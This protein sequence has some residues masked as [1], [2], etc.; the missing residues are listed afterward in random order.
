M[1]GLELPRATVAPPRKADR[2]WSFAG[3][4]VASCVAAAAWGLDHLWPPASGAIL[5]IVLGGGIRTSLPL[6]AAWIEACKGLVKR[7][8]PL[9][10]ILTGASIN[11]EEVAHVGAPALAVIVASIVCGCLAAVLAGRM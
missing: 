7:V 1:E 10:I 3:L 11:L 5:P 8:I 4:L 2:G 6:P 9:T